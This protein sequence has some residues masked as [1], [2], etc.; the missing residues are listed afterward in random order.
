MNRR[1]FLALG[2]AAPLA[3][4]TGPVAARTI[5][6]EGVNQFGEAVVEELDDHEA[7]LRRRVSSFAAPTTCGTPGTTP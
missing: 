5:R 4:L 1:T 7:H 2:A 6:V 3:R